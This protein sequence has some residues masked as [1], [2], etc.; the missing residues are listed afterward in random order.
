MQNRFT[1]AIIRKT[2]E[3]KENYLQIAS[4]RF[5]DG[6]KRAAKFFLAAS[7]G[8]IEFPET[9]ATIAGVAKGEPATASPKAE[10]Q[11]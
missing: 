10:M 6:C 1:I 2:L 7:G 9:L 11:S 4:N 5:S 8:G 3:K